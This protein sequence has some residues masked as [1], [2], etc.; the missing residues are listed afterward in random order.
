MTLVILVEG[1]PREI[2]VKL[3][4]NQTTGLGG[5]AI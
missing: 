4:R 2:P 1:H 5:D 3:S